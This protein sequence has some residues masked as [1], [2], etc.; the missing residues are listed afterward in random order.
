MTLNQIG[1]LILHDL[2]GGLSPRDSKYDRRDIVL[3]A[4]Q[5]FAPLIKTLI[6]EKKA[7]GDTS[8]VTNAIYG[9]ELS[10]QENSAGQKYVSIPTNYMALAHNKGVHRVYAKGNPYLDYVPQSNPGVTSSLPHMQI[11]NVQ[12]YTIEGLNVIFG[13]GCKAK[14]ADK[15]IVQ[16]INP[17]PDTI[18]ANA[19]LPLPPEIIDEAINRLK[20][21]YLSTIS[22]PADMANN[23]NPNIK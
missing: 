10:L 20:Q 2:D 13:K 19:A 1:D 14:K 7:E 8:A 4:R 21:F 18:D 16:I 22:V 15:I 17:L 9:Y 5:V 23:Q 6:F 3:K 12:Y 11:P